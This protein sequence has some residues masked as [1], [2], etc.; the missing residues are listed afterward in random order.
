MP[1]LLHR[2]TAPLCASPLRSNATRRTP[3]KAQHRRLDLQ[4][5]LH[6]LLL[7]VLQP[8]PDREGERVPRHAGA[9]YGA[10]QTAGRDDDVCAC[11]RAGAAESGG[12]A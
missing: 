3:H 11:A 8:R 7:H 6:L 10:A 1:P 12:G 9:C 2:P 4:R 5:H